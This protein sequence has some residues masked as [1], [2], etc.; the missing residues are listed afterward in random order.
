MIELK[1][2]KKKDYN[3]KLLKEKI[4][5]GTSQLENYSKD[6]RINNV[7]KY[8]VV[9]VGNDLKILDLV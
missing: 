2:N 4:E 1:Y 5:E 6:E 9:Y 7:L 3:E 8:L